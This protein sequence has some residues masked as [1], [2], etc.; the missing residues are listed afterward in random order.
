MSRGISGPFT[1]A[2]LRETRALVAAEGRGYVVVSDGLRDLCLRFARD[3][4]RVVTSGWALPTTAHWLALRGAL[5]PDRKAEVE[6]RVAGGEDERDALRAVG[7]PPHELDRAV[8]GY[9]ASLLLDALFWRDPTVDAG[10]GEPTFAERLHQGHEVTRQLTVG[11][12]PVLEAVRTR[13]DDALGVSKLS[14]TLAFSVTTTGDEAARAHLAGCDGTFEG[15]LL[16]RILSRPGT[17]GDALVDEFRCGELALIGNLARLAEGGVVE[18]APLPP[19]PEGDR[20]RCAAMAEALP[21]AACELVRRLALGKACADLEDAPGAARHLARAGWLL[22]GERRHEEA[23]EPLQRALRHEPSDLEAL[24]GKVEALWTLERRD[25]GSSAAQELGGLLLT[26]GLPD[27]ARRVVTAALEVRENSALLKLLVGALEQLGDKQQ[28]GR[29]RSSVA[30]QLRKE[31]RAAEA[32]RYERGEEAAPATSAGPSARLRVPRRPPKVATFVAA[33]VALV[34]GAG[35]ALAYQELASRRDYAAAVDAARSRLAAGDDAGELVTLFPA[36]WTGPSEVGAATEQLRQRLPEY[37]RDQEVARRL[38]ELIRYADTQDLSAVLGALRAA[39]AETPV[40][41]A[42]LQAVRAH[43]DA[44]RQRV[45]RDA[46]DLKRLTKPPRQVDAAF[47]L[48]Q[49]MLGPEYPRLAE[50]LDDPRLRA[51]VSLESRPPGAAVTLEGVALGV[52]T[53][54]V[55]ELPLRGT[56]DV[57]LELPGYAD[58]EAEAVLADLDEPRV[59]Y[60]LER[61]R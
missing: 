42:E 4:V 16:E 15:E 21:A 23:V 46:D 6:R 39:E 47:A 49:E 3:G 22:I 37:G 36:E 31:G 57:R 18:V 56:V 52:E 8:A 43:F 54:V 41:E 17:H 59:V 51:P 11:A 5:E 34:A 55:V 50:V 9:A 60:E 13:L 58:L 14:A 26:A 30:L 53:P 10:A 20:E 2:S 48:A 1:A 35:V 33:G 32:D 25:E 44:R 61:S 38:R 40:L 28:A 19:D 45:L 7:F 29:L 27:Q 24:K 12:E